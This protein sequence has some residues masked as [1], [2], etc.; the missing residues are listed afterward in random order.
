MSERLPPGFVLDPVKPAARA[1]KG[2][3]Q[4]SPSTSRVPAK[5]SVALM[6]VAEP[7]L[8]K[9]M[10]PPPERI[11]ARAG[12]ADRQGLQGMLG[13]LSA[14]CTD[15]PWTGLLQD[16]A[17]GSSYRPVDET[18]ARIHADY[19]TPH[20]PVK[21]FSNARGWRDMETAWTQS[22]QRQMI[23]EG[24]PKTKKDGT[25]LFEI[26]P[27]VTAGQ[28][29]FDS[30]IVESLRSYPRID[31]L[32][33]KSLLFQET[34]M[35]PKKSNEIGY[36]G[37]A[38]LGPS[39]AVNEG[40]LSIGAT[41]FGKNGWK[42]DAEGDERFHPD[43]AIPAGARV[44]DLKI[45]EIDRLLREKGIAE[46]YS[47]EE[48]WQLYLAAY[49]AGQGTVRR[50]MELAIR[51]GIEAPKW[52]QLIAGAPEKSFLWKG[53]TFRNKAEKYREISK[54]PKEILARFQD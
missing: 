35:N 3:E 4:A 16:A 5:K 53:M 17:H 49:N 36:A 41:K 33:Y 29:G 18:C 23:R 15:A 37:I 28:N 26:G 38:Q 54:F 2:V 12:W 40:N 46:Q 45:K 50:V 11:L 24:Q 8:S 39:E 30:L 22:A 6:G 32:I 14:G 42:Y 48:K 34:K 20:P 27:V 47:L 19:A 13:G 52:D 31:P 7:A 51:G 43:R 1:L 10:A 21:R 9:A 25:P 44:L